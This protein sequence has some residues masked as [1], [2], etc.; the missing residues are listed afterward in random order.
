MKSSTNPSFNCSDD[1]AKPKT[2]HKEPSANNSGCGQ[3]AFK[4]RSFP[5]PQ[6]SPLRAYRVDKS[7]TPLKLPIQDVFEAI[8]GQPW[9]KHPEAKQHD[10]A[11]PEAKNYCSF[12]DSKRHQTSQCRS[13]RKYLEDIQ[14]GNLQE[15]IL[16]PGVSSET[17]RQQETLF[18]YRSQYMVTQYRAVGLHQ[19]DK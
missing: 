3:G 19:P 11:R 4:K 6:Q 7:F 17:E 15:Y 10:P 2:Q 1:E 5:H 8:K 9:V 13:F 16:T 12:H 14:Q 18:P